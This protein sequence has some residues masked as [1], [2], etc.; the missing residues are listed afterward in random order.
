MRK[1]RPADQALTY[2]EVLQ[3]LKGRVNAAGE[4]ARS[5]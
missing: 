2:V 1:A 4:L 3:M 5:L